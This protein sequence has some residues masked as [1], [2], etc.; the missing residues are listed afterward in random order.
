MLT[1]ALSISATYVTRE[2]H[3]LVVNLGLLV[4]VSVIDEPDPHVL[5]LVGNS[6]SPGVQGS[7]G[8]SAGEEDKLV[9]VE[10]TVQGGQLLLEGRGGFLCFGGCHFVC[11]L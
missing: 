10:E 4:A 3:S 8:S 7:I 2:K 11:V 6:H 1:C 5:C 9:L